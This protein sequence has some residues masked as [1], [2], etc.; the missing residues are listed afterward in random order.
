M[1][2]CD[3][4]GKATCC[5]ANAFF[6]ESKANLAE[7]QLKKHQN[8]KKRIFWQNVPGVNGLTYH[9]QMLTVNGTYGSG[10]MGFLVTDSKYISQ[11]NK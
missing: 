4:G 10:C 6:T 11:S 2:K 1:V 8:V 5:V 9:I 3:A 7:I